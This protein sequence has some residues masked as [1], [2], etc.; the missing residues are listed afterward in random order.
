MADG[1]SVVTKVCGICT[2]KM[3]ASAKRPDIL[4]CPK[5][6]RP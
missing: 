2:R 5:C 4:F 6:D 1:G 3:K